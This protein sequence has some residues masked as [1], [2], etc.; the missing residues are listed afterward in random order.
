MPPRP[1]LRTLGL[2]ALAL[3]MAATSAEEEDGGGE[4]AYFG[5]SYLD[6]AEREAP[7]DQYSPSGLMLR[8]GQRFNENVAVDFQAGASQTV[9]DFQVSRFTG[10]FLQLG[11]QWERI[12]FYT[13]LGPA[14]AELE[15][16]DTTEVNDGIAYG[17]GARV[18]PSDSFDIVVEWMDYTLG[19]EERLDSIGIGFIRPFGQE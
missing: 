15:M 17:F 8:I 4:P 18:S 7:D 19:A 1:F 11:G 10:L 16:N 6:F 9:S 13:Q 5:G 14:R 3:P 2:L 12:H